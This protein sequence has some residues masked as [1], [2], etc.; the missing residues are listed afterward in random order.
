MDALKEKRKSL[1]FSFSLT[2]K[3]LAQFLATGAKNT[4]LLK[5]HSS[6]I[7]NIFS[8]LEQVQER[9]SLL[10]KKKDSIS[11]FD[12]D[13][14][15]AE[16]Y[17]NIY[18]G[19]KSQVESYLLKNSE[20]ISKQ[21]SFSFALAVKILEQRL[22]TNAE[23]T[24][25][26]NSLVSRLDT[27]FYR[28]E[29]IQNQISK[30]L[31]EENCK[32]DHHDKE[33][34]SPEK[35]RGTSTEMK[36]NLENCLVKDV[37]ESFICNENYWKF[38]IPKYSGDQK[39]C[40]SFWNIV[41]KIYES[42]ELSDIDEFRCFYE[43]MLS[44]VAMCISTFPQSVE[45][46]SK[47]IEQLKL[48]FKRNDLLFQIYVRDLLF[49]MMKNVVSQKNYAD[50]PALYDWMET[51]LR[52]LGNMGL[53]E[54]EFDD[55][56]G[57]LME[58]CLI[59]TILQAWKKISHESDVDDDNSQEEK[60]V[61]NLRQKYAHIFTAAEN[62]TQPNVVEDKYQ[63]T[64][65]NSSQNL[66]AVLNDPR[67]TKREYDL[68]TKTWGD[69]F[70]ESSGLPPTYL[71][72]INYKHFEMY[73]KHIRKGIRR[74]AK[75]K[76]QQ[77]KKQHASLCAEKSISKFAD[78]EEIPKIFLQSDFNLENPST[79]NTVLPWCQIYGQGSAENSNQK[80]S[81]KLWQE[82]MSHYLDI[83]E[84][85]IA[86]Q[87]SMR[88]EAFF[89][90]MTS[91]DALMDQLTDVIKCVCDLRERIHVIEE[92][93][94]T[95]PMKILRL[96]RRQKN[97]KEIYKKLKLIST[98]HQTQPTIQKLL[99][100]SDFVGALDMIYTTQDVLAQELSGI[101]SFR[102]LGSQLAEMEKVIGKMMV[103]DFVRYITADLNRPH[104]ELLVME[105]EKLIAIVFGMLRQNHFRFVQTFK[106]ECFTTI[107]ATVK[108]TVIE[109]VSQSDDFDLESNTGNL[110]EQLRSLSFY[111]WM[112]MFQLIMKNLHFLLERIQALYQVMDDTLEVAAGYIANISTDENFQRCH[113]LHLMETEV[114]IS[115]QDY[116]KIKPNLK[117]VLCSV[118]DHAHDCCAKLL[119]AK[120]KDS[121]LDKLTMPEF[122]SLAKSIEE[123][124]QKSE[125]ISGKQSTALRLALQSQ[126]S[127][128]VMRF[129]E[130]RKVKLNLILEN[131][132]WKQAD[133]PMEFQE[134]VNDIISSGCITS[135]KKNTNENHR[136]PQPYLI[137]NG[138]NFAVCGTALML[139]KM[140]I[141]YCQCAEE[142]PMLAP[143][144]ANRLVELLKAFNSRTCQLVLGAGALQLVGLKTI[145]TKHLA[146]TSRCL[147]LIVYFI[148]Y[149][150]NHFQSKIPVK[151]QKLDKQFD[152]VSKFVQFFST[153][154]FGAYS[155]N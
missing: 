21:K 39:E 110:A 51:K 70:V 60:F 6:R 76:D 74:N 65:Y 81:V 7:S 77:E 29:E 45:N 84:V 121:S 104:T 93:L 95:G 1:R 64:I 33:F 44:R 125:D 27:K 145:T 26:L 105:E 61:E 99:N 13:F 90:A 2:A 8:R 118:C 91:H 144:L 137:V 41:S 78:I 40:S 147:H 19:L 63:W 46:Y 48:K 71:P 119:S 30:L 152:Q 97:L 123:F 92:V 116:L 83:A 72:D 55:F 154:L 59:E 117:D 127:R 58:S 151:Q 53:A 109:V 155:G 38:E 150:K 62:N 131:E 108:Q 142:L 10:L 31:L 153:D 134:L 113:T 100:T 87:I 146:L 12:E 28:L 141:E 32:I 49:M 103:N 56:L 101:H 124:Q 57:S 16:K 79:F 69:N 149:V 66:P 43:S 5:A 148:P 20:Y 23:H 37:P 128:F 135:I 143:D 54:E 115:E 75:K 114:M 94:V 140:I 25:Q 111:K 80:N 129:H 136:E 52:A 36:S 88:S 96:K 139:F 82:K 11:Q 112:E 15:S 107:E 73:L 35:H 122:F 50:L 42:E 4:V 130:E 22:K 24:S 85:H 9:I 18:I 3:N 126:V 98:V 89:H 34:E 86:K 102:H 106:E 14:E 138:E 120:A 67:K 133:V 47:A 132:Q 68:F 17:R